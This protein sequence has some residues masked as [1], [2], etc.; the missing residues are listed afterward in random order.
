MPLAAWVDTL[1]TVDRLLSLEKS[2]RELL[3]AQADEIQCLRDRVSK[4]EEHL[5]IR[6]EKGLTSAPIAA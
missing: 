1:R 2:H 5:N 3:E 4:L 6:E